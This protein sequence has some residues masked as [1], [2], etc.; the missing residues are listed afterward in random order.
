MANFLLIHG[1][2]GGAWVWERVIAGLEAAGH[3]ASAIDLPGQGSDAT[4]LPE[5]TLYRY[6]EAVCDT[7]DGMDGPV[8]LTGHSMGGMV[9][10]QPPHSAPRS[11]RASSTWPPSSP[12][13]ANR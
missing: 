11:S 1:A 5:I 8:V 13:P 2:M 6:A 4:P 10:T 9:T 7:L 3:S 12:S